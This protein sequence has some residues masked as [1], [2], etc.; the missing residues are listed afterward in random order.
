MGMETSKVVGIWKASRIMENKPTTFLHFW[1]MKKVVFHFPLFYFII[2]QTVYMWFGVKRSFKHGVCS[3]EIVDSRYIKK[4]QNKKGRRDNYCAF[5]WSVVRFKLMYDAMQYI[6]FLYIMSVWKIVQW[7]MFNVQAGS[8]LW[9]LNSWVVSCEFWTMTMTT[10][11]KE[12]GVLAYKYV[13][14]HYT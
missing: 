13:H 2:H 9:V 14:I 3:L 6:P 8:E 12:R 10:R 5:M 4:H 1:Y 11:K 7:E